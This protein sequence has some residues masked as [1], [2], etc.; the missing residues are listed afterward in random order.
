MVYFVIGFVLFAMDFLTKFLAKM[1]LSKTGSISLIEGVF[2]LTYVENT[3]AAF[4]M[5]QGRRLFFIA[6]A[7]VFLVV[8][9]V[10]LVRYR[11]RPHLLKLGITFM[12]SGAFGNT[13]DRIANGYVIDFLD[14]ALINFPVF[15]IADIFVCLGAGLMAIFFVF[16]EDKW[17]EEK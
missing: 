1:H 3:G 9:V 17:R 16:Q 10:I 5:M 14:F 7:L 11:F 8:A 15:N 2:N 4:G 13:L 12:L 6:V